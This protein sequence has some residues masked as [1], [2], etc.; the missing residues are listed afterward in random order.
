MP[1]LCVAICP[2]YILYFMVYQ[3]V[4]IYFLNEM[5]TLG[6]VNYHRKGNWKSKH[7]DYHI[8]QHCYKAFEIAISVMRQ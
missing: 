8:L 4:P 3:L 7:F 5:F 6:F 1:E 2:R